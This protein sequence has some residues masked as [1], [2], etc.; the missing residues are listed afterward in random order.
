MLCTIYICISLVGE[1]PKEEKGRREGGEVV[2]ERRGGD[3]GSNCRIVVFT[4]RFTVAG[5]EGGRVQYF[6]DL[7]AN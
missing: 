7:R 3:I 1:C 5:Q 6:D 2:K 4:S